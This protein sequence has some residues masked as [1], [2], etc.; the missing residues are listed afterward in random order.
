MKSDFTFQNKRK[1]NV[2][3]CFN[4][5]PFLRIVFRSDLS[6]GKRFV[7]SS[8]GSMWTG[9]SWVINYWL[10]FVYSEI[11]RLTSV[12]LNLWYVGPFR[13]YLPQ[14]KKITLFT[15][16][17]CTFRFYLRGGQSAAP[18]FLPPPVSIFGCT[19]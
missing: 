12:V 8:T 7:A 11:Q 6:I 10:F 17:K 5:L 19:T 2:N 3:Q 13:F 1:K 9:M 14:S 18:D 4:C 16:V 15:V